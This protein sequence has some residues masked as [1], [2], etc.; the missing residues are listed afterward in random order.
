MSRG[1]HASTIAALATDGFELATLIYMDLPTAVALTDWAVNVVSGSITYISSPD[2]IE[3]GSS[4]ESGELRVN[5]FSIRLSGVSTDWIAVF[6]T[7]AYL[8]SR[9]RMWRVV[10]SSGAVVGTP[11]M[12][13]D[14]RIVGY[15]IKDGPDT[16][17]VEVKIASHWADFERKNGRRTSNASQQQYFP[18]D[19][20]M[21][22]A[23][24]LSR[25]IPW[26]RK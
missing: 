6:T 3:I 19:K 23:K 14:G 20:G 5:E 24:E 2:L 25:D 10:M 1:L 11:I 18:T 26:G 13:F 22:F 4:E 15:S 12:V 21:E 9:F 8:N 16:S 7:T 17:E